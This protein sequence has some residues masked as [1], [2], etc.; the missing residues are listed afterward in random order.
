M[1]ETMIEYAKKTSRVHDW[2]SEAEISKFNAE[3]KTKYI[4]NNIYFIPKDIKTNLTSIEN[5]LSYSLPLDIIEYID[6]FWHPC[7]KGFYKIQESIILFSV[8]KYDNET[9]DAF[10]YHKCGIMDMINTLEKIS[11][12]EQKRYLPIGWTGYSGGYILYDLKTGMIYEED[13]DNVGM[14]SEEPLANSLKELISN[15]NIIK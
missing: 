7:V 5:K 15:L 9:D 6:L 4:N 3:H 14:P 1:K 12:G 10:L 8:I 11:G 2:W 13:F